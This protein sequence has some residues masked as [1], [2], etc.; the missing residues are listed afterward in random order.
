[1]K[2][3]VLSS[4]SSGNSVYL[5]VNNKKILL[6]AGLSFRQL[7]IR[8]LKKNIDISKI[9]YIFI[10]H[11]HRDHVAGLYSVLINTNATI[12][13]TKSTYKALSVN[14][15]E[16]INPINLKFIKVEEEFDIDG[17]KVLPFKTN[18]DA[19]ESVGYRF[20][21]DNKTLVYLTDTGEFDSREELI[22]KECYILES[23]HEKDM[24]LMSARPWVLKERIASNIG[25]LS[26]E[27]SAEVFSN[28]VGPKT[29]TLVLYHL[30][31][32]CNTKDIALLT[33]KNYFKGTNIINNINIIV[34]DKNEP[35]DLIEV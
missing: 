17:I 33:Y 34:S 13:L 2:F 12:Y 10:T 19:A 8:A 18:H 7:S 22:N 28:L 21:Y 30:S 4:S 25:H 29:K 31:S 15:K 14:D 3:S 32:E 9:D 1:M 5:E 23:N 24:L 26:N 11:E 16:R 27:Q 20:E 6:D 35:T